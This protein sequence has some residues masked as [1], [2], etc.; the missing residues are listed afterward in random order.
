MKLGDLVRLRIDYI[1]PYD[2][3]RLAHKLGIIVGVET[4]GEEEDT[5]HRQIFHVAF[6]NMTTAA[7]ENELE[8]LSEA[9]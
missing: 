1:H 2:W 4:H 3:D 5:L 9:R 7:F 6:P 8:V